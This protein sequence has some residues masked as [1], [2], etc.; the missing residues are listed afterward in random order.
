M[1]WKNL[2]SLSALRAFEAAAR[3]RSFSKAATELNVTHAAIAQ[4][5]RSLEAEFSETL[6]QR[7][8]R[9]VVPTP[10]GL[11]LAE[12]LFD[13]FSVISEG[14]SQLKSISQDRPLNLTL[15]PA[16][17]TNWLMPRI[18]EFWSSHPEIKL[19]INPN[20]ALVDLRADGYDLGVRYGEGHWPGLD[21]ELLTDGDFW[22]V[23]TPKLLQGRG[24]TCLAD[25]TDLPWVMEHHM[26]ERRSVAE[27]EGICFSN[28]DV[29]LFSTNGLVMSAA[30][31]DLG[32]T[33]QPKSL[34]QAEVESGELTRVCALNQ[35]GLGYFV[36]TI[37]GREPKGLRQLMKWLRSKAQES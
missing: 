13:G 15:T 17:A 10:H 16:F 21:A 31:A 5:V 23:A 4:H 8:G 30:K 9:G 2:P 7:Q 34:V 19:N 37:P 18:G 28:I 20:T 6:M 27:R 26:M 22:V 29:T 36:V 12:S 25:V 14:V 1:D 3:L 24:Q 33:I 32:V 35:E 11:Q